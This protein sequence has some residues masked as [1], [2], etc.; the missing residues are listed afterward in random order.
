M[1][2]K[3]L[4]IFINDID[5]VFVLIIGV[6]SVWALCFVANR[7]F[8]SEQFYMLRLRR[9]IQK[10]LIG[11]INLCENIGPLKSKSFLYGHINNG[12]SPC[13]IDKKIVVSTDYLSDDSSIFLSKR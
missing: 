1:L 4:T 7:V 11:I 3:I 5:K 6:V 13:D 12:G 9:R 2:K 8:K 10:N